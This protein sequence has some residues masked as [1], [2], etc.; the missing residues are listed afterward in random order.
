MFAWEPT[1]L[2]PYVTTHWLRDFY[3]FSPSLLGP[4]AQVTGR[5]WGC[6]GH[7]WENWRRPA[8][9][10]TLIYTED[11]HLACPLPCQISIN[12]HCIWKAVV[13]YGKIYI[14]IKRDKRRIF[15]TTSLK[16]HPCLFP[17]KRKLFWQLILE[18]L[19]LLLENLYFEKPRIRIQFK[20]MLQQLFTSNKIHK[21]N[22]KILVVKDF[23]STVT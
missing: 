21:E 11:T 15:V 17:R 10:Q 7:S 3:L 23:N 16:W 2:R 14:Q 1:L 4:P 5:V 20:K 13:Q 6:H 9:L 18:F 8:L 12:S 22:W 19:T